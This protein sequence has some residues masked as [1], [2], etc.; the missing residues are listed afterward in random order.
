MLINSKNILKLL[1]VAFEQ[2]EYNL[3]SSI[4]D[5]ARAFSSQLEILIKDSIDNSLFIKTHDTLQFQE[6]YLIIQSR[7]CAIEDSDYSI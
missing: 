1:T 2:L 3:E 7:P 6:D 4:N 5:D